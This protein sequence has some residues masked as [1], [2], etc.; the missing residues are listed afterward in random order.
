MLKKTTNFDGTIVGYPGIEAVFDMF[1]IITDCIQLIGIAERHTLHIV[2]PTIHQ[3]LQKLNYVTG[4]GAVWRGEGKP[5]V[6]LSI[7]SRKLC[8]TLHN[9][10]VDKEWAHPPPFVGYYLNPIFREMEF[11]PEMIKKQEHHS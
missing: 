4:G 9:Y 10:L 7:Y 6:Q 8:L 1:G 5:L 2:L 3:T 11:I